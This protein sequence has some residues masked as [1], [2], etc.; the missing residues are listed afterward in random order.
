MNKEKKKQMDKL[1]QGLNNKYGAG[2]VFTGA[3]AGDKLT[4]KFVESPSIEV[5][6][7]LYG[8]GLS[9]IV[10]IYGPPSSG[11]TKFVIETIALAQKKDPD[12]VVTWLETE[13]SVEL[14]DLQSAGADISRIIFVKQ[15]E[16]GNAERSMEVI[17]EVV[18]QN[19]CDMF[20]VNSIAGLV[21]KKETA[22]DLTQQNIALI[23]RL[24]SR[25]FRE[26]TG[27]MGKSKITGIFINQVRTNVGQMFGNPETTTGGHALRFYASQR[28][29]FNKVTIQ[30]SDPIGKEEGVKISVIINKNRFAGTNNPF[31]STEYF[32]RYNGGIDRVTPIPNALIAAGLVRSSGSY[33]Y[34]EDAKGKVRT[35]AGVECKFK[36]KKEFIKSLNENPKL[37]EHFQNL[38]K[39]NEAGLI[40]NL[41]EDEYDEIRQEDAAGE[42]MATLFTEIDKEV[43][44]ELG[45]GGE[46]EAD[47]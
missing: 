16:L 27:A 36:S 3:T 2:T 32:A 4:P 26:I 45:E 24:L 28:L 9:K 43:V 14:S 46:S 20:V 13:D 47:S 17:R 12:Y 37:L 7:A 35:I 22:D 21:P 33:V 44:Q 10:E 30:A 31:R 23:A 29:R 1:I 11:K 38:A 19:M 42:A 25:F 15:E 34:Y 8:R 18:Y 39:Q 6:T 5:Q 40:R 41:T